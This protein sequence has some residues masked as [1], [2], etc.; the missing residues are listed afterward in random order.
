MNADTTKYMVVSLDHNAIRSHSVNTESVEDFKYLETNLK[1]QNSIQEEFKSSLKSGNVCYHSV[2]NLLPSRSLS[3]NI[4]IK[5]HRS[6]I[7]A[8]VLYGFETWSVTLKE[9][10]RLR[11][12]ENRVVGKIFGL[13]G[14]EVTGEW[15][16]LHNDKLQPL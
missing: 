14:K 12:L 7:L 15:R 2:R 8:V 10:H 13:K 4:K 11:L 9:E 3:K 6:I 1:N 5:T 16:R